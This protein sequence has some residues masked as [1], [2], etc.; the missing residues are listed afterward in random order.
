MFQGSGRILLVN[1]L[2]D[3]GF[4]NI[5]KCCTIKCVHECRSV[6]CAGQ[7]K[8]PVDQE[9]WN[10]GDASLPCPRFLRKHDAP[11]QIVVQRLIDVFV[12]QTM[13]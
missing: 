5:A 2:G 7:E 13:P 11:G 6:L 3:E 12:V 1:S 4:A 8:T 10:S 9:V